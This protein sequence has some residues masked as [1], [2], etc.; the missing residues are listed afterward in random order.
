[1]IAGKAFCH[2]SRIDSTTGKSLSLM[3]FIRT[4]CYL[5]ER[6][7]PA[8]HHWAPISPRSNL[9]I[10]TMGD[11]I[12]M[13]FTHEATK[14]HDKVYALLGMCSDDLSKAGLSPDYQ[15]PWHILLQRLLK[16]VVSEHICV[17]TRTDRQIAVIRSKGRCLAKVTKTE[18]SLG[19]EEQYGILARFTN[20][21]D[22]AGKSRALEIK[23]VLRNSQ[24]KVEQG[25][26]ICLLQGSTTCTIL[27]P[28]YDYFQDVKISLELPQIADGL[29]DFETLLEVP[30]NRE[31]LLVWDREASP[32]FNES[33]ASS[34]TSPRNDVPQFTFSSS[35]DD[36]DSWIRSND[37]ESAQPG[38]LS[39]KHMGKALRTLNVALLLDD[40]AELDK[41]VYDEAKYIDE[42]VVAICQD[43]IEN[44]EIG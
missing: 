3:S 17:E 5:I 24:F 25:D 6:S 41:E 31:L 43:A 18:T 8:T 26:L 9:A 19:E 1:M 4:V 28:Y 14:R 2:G 30:C 20:L 15:L 16:H 37:W 33:T 21:P 34:P 39:Q 32:E 7:V 29:P 10:A 38:L 42:E 23:F 27:R 13:Y 35:K 40:I 44:Y 22:L 11:L 36:Y 12:E